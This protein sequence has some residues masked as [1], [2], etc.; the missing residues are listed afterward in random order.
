MGWRKVYISLLFT[1]ITVVD[2]ISLGW[3][4]A[5]DETEEAVVHALNLAFSIY[6]LALTVHSVNQN[7][8]SDH[9]NFVLHLTTLTTLAMAFLG[10]TAI[11][12]TTSPTVPAVTSTGLQA[13]WLV[14]LSLYMVICIVAFTMPQG[15]RLRFPPENIYSEK[16]ILGITTTEEENV[17]GV[18]GKFWLTGMPFSVDHF[19]SSRFPLGCSTFLIYHES[20]MAKQCCEKLRTRRFAHITCIFASH[21]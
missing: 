17:C 21:C 18:S 10:F 11:L 5:N 12:P 7:I 6:V 16:T 8:A 15:P 14:K 9:S 19:I 4:L 3:S 1:V 2:A 13:L 20:R